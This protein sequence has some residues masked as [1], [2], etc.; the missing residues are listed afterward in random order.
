MKMTGV[1][2]SVKSCRANLSGWRYQLH[3]IPSFLHP[4]ARTW[5]FLWCGRL[6]LHFGH[7]WNECRHIHE[8]LLARAIIRTRSSHTK[9]HHANPVVLMFCLP[10]VMIALTWHCPWDPP[11]TSRCRAD[12]RRSWLWCPLD[13]DNACAKWVSNANVALIND[14]GSGQCQNPPVLAKRFVIHCACAGH[15]II[16]R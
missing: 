15:Y 11:Q 1:R 13:D 2:G 14:Y 4:P 9:V 6:F 8:S 16:W 7:P 3:E 12:A 10:P 5:H